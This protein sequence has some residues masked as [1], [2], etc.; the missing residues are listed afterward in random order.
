MN[1]ME[2]SPL[3]SF[4]DSLL[5]FTLFISMSFGVAFAVSSYT[6]HRDAMAQQAAALKALVGEGE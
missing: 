6:A 2:K 3:G 5:V 4:L 1:D